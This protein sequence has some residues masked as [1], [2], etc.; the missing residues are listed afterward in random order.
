[1]KK[2]LIM[3]LCLGIC[4]PSF[5][6]PIE[7]YRDK[8]DPQVYRGTMTRKQV[9]DMARGAVKGFLP[10]YV[11][12]NWSYWGDGKEKAAIAA[13][14]RAYNEKSYQAYFNAAVVWATK[15]SFEGYDNVY[16]LNP[17]S[18]IGGDYVVSAAIGFADRA[19]EKEPGQPYMYLLRGQVQYEQ[20]VAYYPG[21]GR[22]AIRE[23]KKY[24]ADNAWS[25]FL[26]VENI[27]P[28]IAPYCDM[29]VLAGLLKKGSKTYSKYQRKCRA[30]FAQV[31]G[32]GGEDFEGDYAQVEGEEGEGFEGDGDFAQVDESEV[33]Q[34]EVQ[35]SLH[36]GG[37]GGSY[38]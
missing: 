33:A 7:G 15:P 31:E 4:V 18:K 10:I 38:L 35:A 9:Y 21:N 26:T 36:V 8:S 6:F 28:S 17:Q 14:R 11:T 25:D 13:K 1:M 24:M 5:S 30:Q 3:L 37:H 2:L 12:E 29:A 22:F 32:E 23:G 27:K 19:I 34:R 16:P 20:G